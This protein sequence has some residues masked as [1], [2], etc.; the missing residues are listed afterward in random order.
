MALACSSEDFFLKLE[1]TVFNKK[2]MA[3]LDVVGGGHIQTGT[4]RSAVSARLQFVSYK[5][6]ISHGPA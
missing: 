2:V 5:A 6:F 3:Y 4:P 1:S